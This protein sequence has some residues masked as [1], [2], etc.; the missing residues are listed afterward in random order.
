MRCDTDLTEKNQTLSAVIDIHV[1]RKTITEA[2]V[3]SDDACVCSSP[4]VYLLLEVVENVNS[5]AFLKSGHTRCA[6]TQ[7]RG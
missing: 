5:L 6:Y 2:C 7:M 1:R 3:G 4:F